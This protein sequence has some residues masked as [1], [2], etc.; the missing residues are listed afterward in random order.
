MPTIRPSAA[1]DIPAIAAIYR[2]HVLHGTGTFEI[3]PPCE[4]DMAAR[5]ADVLARGLPW[6]VAEKDGQVLGFAYANWFKPRPAY[7]FSAEDS[8]YVSDSARGLGLGR[9]LLT[10]VAT[11]AEAA[12]VRKL[13]AV[14]GD[15]AN[16][17]SIGVHRALGFTEVGIMRSVGW[18]F[19]AW[20]D[21]VLMEKP[22][23]E[24]DR[25]APE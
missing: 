20:R 11:Q 7:R 10:E 22:L 9:R 1:S 18:K 23:G 6:L 12:G 5:R 17:G 13:L 16:A 8:I 21:I 4:A 2:H 25:T 24:A 15:S 19:G 3:D 14:I